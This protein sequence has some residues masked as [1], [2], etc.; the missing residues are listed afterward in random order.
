MFDWFW[1]IVY[2]KKIRYLNF[3]WEH[4][5]QSR[6]YDA[7]EFAETLCD[8][9]HIEEWHCPKCEAVVD[10]SMKTCKCGLTLYWS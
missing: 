4:S 6:A 1:K 2:R 9:N 8:P 5:P 3:I 10:E 7:D